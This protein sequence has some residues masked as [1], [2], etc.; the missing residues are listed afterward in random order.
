MTLEDEDYKLN[1]VEYLGSPSSTQQCLS[2]LITI[3]TSSQRPERIT[4]LLGPEVDSQ[5]HPHEPV[6]FIA[7]SYTEGHFIIIP[8]GFGTHGGGGGGGLEKALWLINFYQIPMDEAE[9]N[10]KKQFQRIMT[11]SP[12]YSDIQFIQR[13]VHAFKIRSIRGYT[14]GTHKKN[15]TLKDIINWISFP[16]WLIE[17]ELLP[18][19]VNFED[20]P[21]S[22]VFHCAKR[23]EIMIRQASESTPDKIGVPL[24]NEV[25]KLGGILEPIAPVASEKESW[26]H[27]YRGAMGAFRN[28]AGHRDQKLS[29]DDALGQIMTI[30]MLVR[31]LKTDYPDKFKQKKKAY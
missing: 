1:C 6:G 5:D 28:P 12:M 20:R 2:A 13:A 26:A 27:L 25:I 11:K 21:D 16:Y 8:N 15:Y 31:K 9:I 3:L 14:T 10:D 18:E 22:A 7:W 24:V 19:V 29:Q 30:N 4:A 17:E 23:L